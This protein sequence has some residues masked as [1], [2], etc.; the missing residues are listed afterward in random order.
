MLLLEEEEN[1]NIEL[2]YEVEK[3]SLF[4]KKERKINRKEIHYSGILKMNIID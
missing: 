4:R 3:I 2:N 1:Q